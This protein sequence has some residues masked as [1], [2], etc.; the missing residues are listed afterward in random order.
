MNEK[1]L[2]LCSA[3]KPY[4]EIM[5]E[6][7]N[8]NY[9]RILSSPY[10]AQTGELGAVLIYLYDSLVT[11]DDKMLSEVFECVAETEMKH[12]EILGRLI[13][14]LG[15]DPR[16]CASS[17]RGCFNTAQLPYSTDKDRIIRGAIAA[18]QNAID[19]YESIKGMID[20][21][22]IVKIIDRMIEDEKIH[23]SIFTELQ[24]V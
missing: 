5:T 24:K 12:M 22:Y 3:K 20:D 23:L 19:E 7:R 11:T 21:R 10:A 6:G 18:E 16:Y 1:L 8:L 2:T 4:P 14:L 17:A 15:G 13:V 9:A